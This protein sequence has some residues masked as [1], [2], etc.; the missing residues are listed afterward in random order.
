MAGRVTGLSRVLRGCVTRGAEHCG[1]QPGAPSSS[2]SPKPEDLGVGRASRG[3][4]KLSSCRPGACREQPGRAQ[5]GH[6]LTWGVRAASAPKEGVQLLQ[7]EVA[8]SQA[9]HLGS[10]RRRRGDGAGRSHTPGRQRATLRVPKPR[11][12]AGRGIWTRRL[13]LRGCRDAALPMLLHFCS[14]SCLLFRIN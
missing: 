11:P 14:P 9:K 8:H 1:A 10:P 13:R 12:R 7:L 2:G 6:P 3:S 4:S 5:P